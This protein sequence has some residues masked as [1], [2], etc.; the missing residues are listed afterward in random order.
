MFRHWRVG[1]EHV[2]QANENHPRVGLLGRGQAWLHQTSL[3]KHI[4]G[5]AK[6]DQGDGDAQDSV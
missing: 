4:H 5:H 6:H 2:H 3:P 1:Q